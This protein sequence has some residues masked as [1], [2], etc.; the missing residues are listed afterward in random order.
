MASIWTVAP[1]TTRL[2]LV[3][4][5]GAGERHPLWVRVKRQLTV[6]ESRRI[7]TAGWGGM[8]TGR[9]GGGNEIAI[10]WRTQGFARAEVYLTD[11][12][13]ADHTGARLPV[14]REMIEELHPAV[15][16]LIEEALTAH[17][18]AAGEEKKATAGD[19]APAATSA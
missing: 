5:D 15:F 17:V 7:M 8:S 13:L 6:G 3:Y 11:W 16:A 9:A 19:D 10:D 18:A 14:T 2:D 12:S 1:E 4:V